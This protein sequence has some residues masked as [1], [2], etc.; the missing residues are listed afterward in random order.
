MIGPSYPAAR[1]VAPKIE[2]HFRRRHAAERAGRGAAMDSAVPDPPTIERLIDAAFWASLRREEGYVPKISLALVPPER[3]GQPL[4]LSYRLPLDASTLT[5]VAPAVERAG[6]H[7]GVWRDDGELRVWGTTRVIPAYTFV[8]EVAAPG[9]LVIKH[10]RGDGG[11]F[12]ISQLVGI[13]T[14]AIALGSLDQ[15]SSYD[16]L[17]GKTPA[18]RLEEIKKQKLEF[19]ELTKTIGPDFFSSSEEMQS[20]YRDRVKIY[21]EV[22]ALRWLKQQH[23]AGG[24]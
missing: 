23:V 15:N 9:L 6:I 14:E 20:G 24:P 10:H 22:A 1:A 12:V 16:F 7:L 19:R 8:L 13:A 21:G 2:A 17:G 5:K 4:C 11:K 3:A 18:Q